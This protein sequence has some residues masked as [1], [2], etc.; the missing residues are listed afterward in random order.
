MLNE[1]KAVK[2]DSISHTRRWFQDGDSDLFVWYAEDK[3]IVGFQFTYQ[4]ER[5]QKALSWFVDKGCSHMNV[6]DGEHADLVQK[7]S[8]ILVPDGIFQEEDVMEI[9]R[10]RSSHIDDEIVQ[11]VTARIEKFGSK[12]L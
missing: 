3:S 1:V 2:Q 10:A 11:L 12:G 8:P 5:K 9:F 4:Y 7:M 6:D